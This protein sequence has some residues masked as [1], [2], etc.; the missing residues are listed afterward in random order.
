MVYIKQ[1]TNRDRAGLK[2]IARVCFI[3]FN[4]NINKCG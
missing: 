3:D 4:T 1:M 2:S